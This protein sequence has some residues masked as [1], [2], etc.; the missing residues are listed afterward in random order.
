MDPTETILMARDPTAEVFPTLVQL[1]HQQVALAGARAAA[2]W[3]DEERRRRTSS[4]PSP[5]A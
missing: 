1:V 3:I 5:S 2:Q 4:V